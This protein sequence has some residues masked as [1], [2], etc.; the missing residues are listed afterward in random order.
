[1]RSQI[2]VVRDEAN[3]TIS[4]SN[5]SPPFVM[6]SHGHDGIPPVASNRGLSW[7]LATDAVVAVG[8]NVLIR[9][10]RRVEG[11]ESRAH[12][13]VN[14]AHAGPRVDAIGCDDLPDHVGIGQTIGAGARKT[15]RATIQYELNVYDI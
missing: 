12:V 4:E 2:N 9:G 3:G 13:L 11:G 15:C 7:A 14:T 6:A 10:V 5:L 8:D 1:M